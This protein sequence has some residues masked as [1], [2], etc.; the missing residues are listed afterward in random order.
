MQYGILLQKHIQSSFRSSN[1][2]NKN[3][4]TVKKVE[5]IHIDF[6]ESTKS[7]KIKKGCRLPD[8]LLDNFLLQFCNKFSQLLLSQI[9]I[10]YL[11][12]TRLII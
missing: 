4:K 6:E 12:D 3:F 11:L 8:Y 1:I 9:D 5:K 2:Q 7:F 10:F